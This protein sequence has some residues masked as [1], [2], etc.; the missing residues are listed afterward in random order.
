MARKSKN[1]M[2]RELSKKY[3]T[4]VKRIIS[5]WKKGS[6]DLEISKNLG[7]DLFTLQQIKTD[8]ELAHRRERVEKKREELLQAGQAH[9]EH[10]SFFSPF[11]K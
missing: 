4:N 6:G 10:Q 7:I 1:E 5:A 11:I 3:R 8:I 2:D 9:E